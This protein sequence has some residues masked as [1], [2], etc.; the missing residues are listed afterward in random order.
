MKK[1]FIIFVFCI[2]QIIYVYCYDIL[3]TTDGEEYQGELI[4]IN[5]NEIKINI[6]GEEKI[7]ERA[8]VNKIRIAEKSNEINISEIEDTIL[9]N[10]YNASLNYDT[11][12]FDYTILYDEEIYKI[13]DNRITKRIILKIHTEEGKEAAANSIKYNILYETAILNFARVINSNS[14]VFSI[15][16]TNIEYSDVYSQ[17]PEYNKI[18]EIKYVIKQIEL[19]S[20]IDYSYTII[21]SSNNPVNNNYSISFFQTNVPILEKRIIIECEDKEKLYIKK[22]NYNRIKFNE[23]EK[24]N[25]ND[26]QLTILCKNIE[27]LKEE[28]LVGPDIEY[29]PYVMF[30]YNYNWNDLKEYIKSKNQYKKEE[31][32]NIE[33]IKNFNNDD[34]LENAKNIYDYVAKEIKLF[35]VEININ[36][37]EHLSIEKINKIRYANNYDKNYFLYQLLK[38]FNYDAEL[39]LVKKNNTGILISEIPS[40]QQFNSSI[41]KLQINNNIFYLNPIYEN[42]PFGYLSDNYEDV[43]ALN[44]TNEKTL[45]EKIKIHSIENEKRKYV[46]ECEINNN[47]DLI[48]SGKIQ[49]KGLNNIYSKDLKY[50]NNEERKRRLT[51]IITKL[52][53]K[54]PNIIEQEIK[55][56]E[57]KEKETEINFKFMIKEY[58]QNIEDKYLI[59]KMPLLNYSAADVSEEEREYPLF[60]D[61]IN[62]NEI[63]VEIKIPDNYKINYLP[64]DLEISIENHYSLNLFKV[65]EEKII[66][67]QIYQ[68]KNLR[69]SKDYY[70]KYKEFKERLSRLSEDRCVLKAK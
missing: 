5:E 40:L 39:L 68:T 47:G 56:L 17:L 1:I 30:S 3:Y 67:K 15:P 16:K 18:K 2:F 21:Q 57:E 25:E 69:A 46:L 62:E 48:G 35:D 52:F 19:G 38:Y 11:D 45:F 10:V 27:P 8:K 60:F 20:L 29:I 36:N 37:F 51:K 26:Y 32:E 41:V 7:F 54:N 43:E 55:N 59:F 53:E 63:L 13:K 9:K 61:S 23:E 42:F 66:Y 31:I 12:T 33:I 44:I 24:I 50:L 34:K 58:G 65:E 49:F 14:F 4:S 70:K 64:G 6:N 28:S 22:E